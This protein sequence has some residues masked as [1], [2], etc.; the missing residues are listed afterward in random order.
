MTLSSISLMNA[1][2]IE[3]LRSKGVTNKELIAKVLSGDVTPWK[4][5]SDHFDF[6]QLI[7]L[8]H[9]NP[10]NF[11]KM[12]NQGYTV[13]FVT[14]KGVKNLLKLKFNKNEGRDY[15][16]KDYTFT[17]LILNNRELVQLEQILSKNWRLIK[18][19]TDYHGEK[20]RIEPVH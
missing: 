5:L 2:L 15:R 10:G 3:T 6:T 9:R 16:I 1:Y 20:V 7:V 17:D 8:A 11:E 4:Y 18:V 13:K 19:G 12:I 14:F